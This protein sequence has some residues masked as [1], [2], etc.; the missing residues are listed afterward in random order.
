MTNHGQKR[1]NIIG[2]ALCN[3]TQRNVLMSTNQYMK[4]EFKRTVQNRKHESM[5][6]GMKN[7]GTKKGKYHWRFPVQ[8]KTVQRTD[9]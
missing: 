2:G 4:L 8:C 5:C 3:A 7:C 9:E 6:T 1:K